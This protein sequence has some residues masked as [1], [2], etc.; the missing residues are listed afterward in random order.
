M[1]KKSY[2]SS[3]IGVVLVLLVFDYI[4]LSIVQKDSWNIQVQ[5]IQN[6][7]LKFKTNP[8]ILTYL[9]MVIVILAL[10]VSRT[11]KETLLKDSVIWGGL[12]GLA[13]YGVFNGTNYA[14]FKN[15]QLNTAIKDTL[16][17]I[18]LCIVATYIGGYLHR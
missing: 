3:F 11:K 8:A 13:M 9:V 7:P 5:L 12:I 18:F 17:G 2:V 1:D 10:S 4:W 15:Y 16:W 14:I 6:S